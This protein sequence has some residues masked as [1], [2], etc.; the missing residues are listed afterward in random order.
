MINRFDT[1][2]IFTIAFDFKFSELFKEFGPL[3]SKLDNFIFLGKV[4]FDKRTINANFELNNCSFCNNADFSKVSFLAP[5]KVYPYSSGDITIPCQ[6]KFITVSF[7]R[8][9]YFENTIFNNFFFKDVDFSK[10]KFK[11]ADFNNCLFINVK[12]HKDKSLLGKRA[13]LYDE[14]YLSKSSSNLLEQLSDLERLYRKLK[15]IAKTNEDR[16]LEGEFYYGENEMIRKRAK[17]Y[18][19]PFTSKFWYFLAS[20]YGERP[21]WA[22]INI[23]IL[24]FL[25]SIGYICTGVKINDTNKLLNYCNFSFSDYWY[26]LAHAFSPIT[27]NKWQ[28]TKAANLGTYFLSI[29]EG[30]ILAVQIGLFV[31]A[32]RR[33]FQR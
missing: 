16:D 19:Q 30:A 18:K 10:S 7:L 8:E 32:F 31:M 23:I 9:A 5:V 15:S 4:I 29:A 33:K 2:L 25:F 20:R 24:I 17:W 11:G 12:W 6:H 26:Y 28:L 27:L 1:I 14:K 3:T 13:S 22:F 21:S